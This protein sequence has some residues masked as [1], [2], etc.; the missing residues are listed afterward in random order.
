MFHASHSHPLDFAGALVDIFEFTKPTLNIMD[1]VIGM[2]GSGPSAGAPRKMGAIIASIDAVALDAVCAH[3]IGYRPKEIGM[4][5]IAYQRKLGEINLAK[6]ELIGEEI[7]NL[8]QPDWK[9]PFSLFAKLKWLPKKSL[10][11]LSPIINQI[12]IWPEIDQSKCKKCL[13]CFNACPVKTIEYDKETK[14]IWVNRKNCINCFCC[15]ELC[16]YKA[17][18]LKSSWLADLMGLGG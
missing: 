6:I 12:K 13:I 10:A 9:K 2:E 18:N 8:R 11:V 17:I 14:K 1:A 16:E 7:E 4:L 3:L 5:A 15:H